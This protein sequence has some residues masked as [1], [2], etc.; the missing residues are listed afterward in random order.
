MALAA[1][2]AQSPSASAL[3]GIKRLCGHRLVCDTQPYVLTVPEAES[4]VIDVHQDFL[5]SISV[6]G[7]TACSLW[8]L[9]VLAAH[10]SLDGQPLEQMMGQFALDIAAEAPHNRRGIHA[11]A[12]SCSAPRVGTRLAIDPWVPAGSGF[13]IWHGYSQTGVPRVRATMF[14]AG[15]PW[16]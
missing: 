10:G 8:A 14:K 5:L 13:P 1:P 11:Q 16:I 3:P 2:D 6:T 15:Q 9:V 7:R 12:H 4:M